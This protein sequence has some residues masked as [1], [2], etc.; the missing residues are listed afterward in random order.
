MSLSLSRLK[1][2]MKIVE[3]TEGVPSGLWMDLKAEISR[4]TREKRKM[5]LEKVRTKQEG[6][7]DGR[8]GRDPLR[9]EEP[10]TYPGGDR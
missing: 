8:R 5:T 3:V 1:Q 7:V 4:L 2:I 10:F 6:L 9:W